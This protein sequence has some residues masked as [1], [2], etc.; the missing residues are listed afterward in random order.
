MIE[1]ISIEIDDMMKMIIINAIYFCDEWKC[2]FNKSSTIKNTQFK[3]F[4]GNETLVDMMYN[5]D[6][7]MYFNTPEYQAIRMDYVTNFFMLVILPTELTKPRLFQQN[8]IASLCDEMKLETVHLYF[9][10]FTYE[11]THS[12]LPEIINAGYK[13]NHVGFNRM[14]E[15]DD[16]KQGITEIV[17]VAKII[18]DERGTKAAAVTTIV[19]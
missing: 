7:Y 17:Q 8:A 4:Q 1:Q 14:F 9:P 13:I 6:Q 12:L 5:K 2:P 19:I 11:N 3:T 15:N 10:R 16:M 18:V